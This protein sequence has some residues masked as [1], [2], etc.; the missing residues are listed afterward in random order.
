VNK[1]PIPSDD[2]ILEA[3]VVLVEACH[4]RAWNAGWYHDPQTG[5][6]IQ[7]N[8]GEMVALIHSEISEALEGHRK[9]LMDDKLP[10]RRMVPVELFDA[11]IRIMDLIGMYFPDDVPALLE[12]MHYNDQ[13]ADH[14]PENR[15]LVD[16]KKF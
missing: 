9:G 11:V 13:R 2:D 12:K 5:L 8:M 3:T 15:V 16:G 4:G 1:K 10:H 6:E 7:R 14:K